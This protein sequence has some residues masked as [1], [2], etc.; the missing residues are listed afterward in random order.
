MHWECSQSQQLWE[1]SLHFPGSCGSLKIIQVTAF[2]RATLWPICEDKCTLAL[3]NK[4]MRW[5][6]NSTEL[7]EELQKSPLLP[8]DLH[9]CSDLFFKLVLSSPSWFEISVISNSFELGNKTTELFLNPTYKS[10]LDI[11][12]HDNIN[13]DQSPPSIPIKQVSSST[14]DLLQ[15]GPFPS[16]YSPDLDLLLPSKQSPIVILS[17]LFVLTKP[18]PI[19]VSFNF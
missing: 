10:S 3:S 9:T 6:S 12:T 4:Q 14:S 2:S 19:P 8:R 11:S 7:Y 1:N 16:H 13:I 17:S 18:P 5:V 15:K